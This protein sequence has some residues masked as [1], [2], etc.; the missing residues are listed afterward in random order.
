MGT[1]ARTSRF[2]HR[3]EQGACRRASSMPIARGTSGWVRRLSAVVAAEVFRAV[4][5]KDRA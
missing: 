4:Q 3:G 5:A 2:D 1:K